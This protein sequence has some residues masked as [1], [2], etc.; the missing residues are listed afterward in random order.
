MNLVL[1]ERRRERS[2]GWMYV[3]PNPLLPFIWFRIAVSASDPA[4][5]ITESEAK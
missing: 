1:L 3:L 2:L 5:L 4:V